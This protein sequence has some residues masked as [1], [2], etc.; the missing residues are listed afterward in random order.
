[1]KLVGNLIRELKG[2]A[3]EIGFYGF[4]NYSQKRYLEILNEIA[5]ELEEKIK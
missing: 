3:N 5:E 2:I 1:M 4:A